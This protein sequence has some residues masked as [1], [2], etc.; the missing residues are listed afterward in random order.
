MQL[1][2]LGIPYTLLD[3]SVEERVAQVRAVLGY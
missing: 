2:M 3:G 1:D